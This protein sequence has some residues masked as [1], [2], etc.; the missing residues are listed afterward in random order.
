MN[1]GFGSRVCV[2]NV[3]GLTPNLLP[4]APRLAALGIGLSMDQPAAGGHLHVSGD[5]VDRVVPAR[6][7]HRR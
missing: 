7:R 5:D 6:A 2:I 1:Q 4:H 3:V